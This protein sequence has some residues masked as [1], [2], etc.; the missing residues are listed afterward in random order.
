MSDSECNCERHHKRSVCN[1]N[2]CSSSPVFKETITEVF[3]NCNT[4]CEKGCRG[5]RGHKG[6]PG[7]RGEKGERGCKGE[8]G[9]RG[10]KGERGC[11]GEQGE[12]GCK[13]ERGEQGCRGEK[14]E[15][16]CKGER[17]EQGCKGEKGER[18]PTGPA[19]PPGPSCEQSCV[20]Y[21]VHIT[22]TCYEKKVYT[23]S[24]KCNLIGYRLPDKTCGDSDSSLTLQFDLGDFIRIK[25]LKCPDPKLKI[26][27][28]YQHEHIKIYG[29]ND[30]DVLGH[31]LYTYTNKDY[32][33]KSKELIIPSFDTTNKSREGD[34]CTYGSIPYRYITVSGSHKSIELCFL[35]WL[36]E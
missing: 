25:N 26:G 36:C 4:Y 2:R 14:G 22:H 27:C 34:L 9:C 32:D 12:R 7:C 33:K 29:S 16:G 1:C 8:Q 30:P 23:V 21:P 11:K 10:E 19:G 3:K 6:E 5:E 31:L 17:G 13:G 15:R 28:I 20:H 18:G 35:L 24:N